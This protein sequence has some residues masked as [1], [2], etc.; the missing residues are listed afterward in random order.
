MAEPI[1][2]TGAG[3]LLAHIRHGQ[4]VEAPKSVV[5]ANEAHISAAMRASKLA[6]DVNYTE[7]GASPRVVFTPM[8]PSIAKDSGTGGHLEHVLAMIAAGKS[9][10]VTTSVYTAHE[11]TLA[12]A[13]AASRYYWEAS[14]VERATTVTLT[15]YAVS[16]SDTKSPPPG[17]YY[18]VAR[19]SGTSKSLPPASYDGEI[20]VVG[21]DPAYPGVMVGRID[22]TGKMIYL[23]GP[24]KGKP[25]AISPAELIT[26]MR[27]EMTKTPM[28]TGVGTAY[29]YTGGGVSTTTGTTTRL[30]GVTGIRA[31]ESPVD[32]D[33]VDTR[34]EFTVPSRYA[35]EPLTGVGDSLRI[36]A[37]RTAAYMQAD[38]RIVLVTPG[39]ETVSDAA[40]FKALWRYLATMLAE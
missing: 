32:L 25:C 12:A 27:P 10:G 40:K 24:G 17:G 15:P 37:M 35:V 5:E 39:T 13:M 16:P 4:A 20:T 29:P 7:R 14:R 6:W 26:D 2:V 22:A 18:D 19:G 36:Q 38:C 11:A 31:P 21:M 3:T 30:P 1:L 28:T 23:G 9:T 34:P 33:A 8:E